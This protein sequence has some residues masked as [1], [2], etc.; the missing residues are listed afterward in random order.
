MGT[1]ELKEKLKDFPRMFILFSL[2]LLLL[3][4]SRRNFDEIGI[5]FF[6]SIFSILIFFELYL[7]RSTLLNVYANAIAKGGV[8]YWI[9]R[10]KTFNYILT[11]IISIYLAASLLLFS[12]LADDMELAIIATSGVFLIII[13]PFVKFVVA[14][15]VNP[16]PAKMVIKVG[17]ISLFVMLVILIDG[18]YT[19][20]G[21]TNCWIQEQFDESIPDCVI[22][23]VN[24]SYLYFQHLLRFIKFVDLN[25]GSIGFDSQYTYR[26]SVAR[27]LL[28]LSPTPY[29]AYALLLLSIMS[30]RRIVI[31]RIS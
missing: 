9:L 10:D 12:N 18:A 8:V 24:H 27:F 23:E 17:A 2:S 22:A 26:F 1:T 19:V 14:P 11:A 30:I 13:T 31:E 5:W 28:A 21:P 4:L 25:I 7:I 6:L 29:I 20:W 3:L 16:E 15:N